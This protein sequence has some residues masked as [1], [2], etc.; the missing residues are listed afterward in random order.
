MWMVVV[1]AKWERLCM[2]SVTSSVWLLVCLVTNSG[3][4]RLRPVRPVFC[5]S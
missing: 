1:G 5:R 3:K 2:Y 4:D